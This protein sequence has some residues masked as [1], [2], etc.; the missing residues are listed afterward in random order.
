MGYCFYYVCWCTI[1][2]RRCNWFSLVKGSLIPPSPTPATTHNISVSVTD[3]TDP[4]GN[5][6]VT[7]SDGENEYTG[8]TGSA[9]GCTISNVPE[10]QYEVVA[11]KSGYV[12]YESTLTVNSETSSLSIVL[13]ESNPTPQTVNYAFTSYGDAQGETEWGSGTVKTTGVVSGGYTEVEVL[14]N[15]PEESF[16]GQKFYIT[17]DAQTNGTIYPLYTDAGT[18]SAGIYVSITNE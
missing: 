8:K 6:D 12:D 2:R 18:T 3:G 13:E 14:T 7:L 17:S 11:S 4:I 9:G 10:G 16:V 1:C 5:V 15:S